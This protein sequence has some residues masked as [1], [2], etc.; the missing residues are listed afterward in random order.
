MIKLK[1]VKE[2]ISHPPATEPGV[3]KTELKYK[4]F[5]EQ[6]DLLERIDAVNH[7]VLVSERFLLV[8]SSDNTGEQSS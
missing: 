2:Q 6:H 7:Y 8:S 4:C 5:I 3:D 1:P